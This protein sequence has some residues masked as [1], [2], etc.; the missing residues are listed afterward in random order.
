MRSSFR[1]GS[2]SFVEILANFRQK[3]Q[4][5]FLF[6]GLMLMSKSNDVYVLCKCIWDIGSK[7]EVVG[8]REC[9]ETAGL[10]AKNDCAGEDQQQ[11]I[12]PTKSDWYGRVG[13][14]FI[15]LSLFL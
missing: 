4:F 7:Y 11:F 3:M 6:S 9:G 10:G 13:H 12:R 8:E 5:L 15:L 2:A 1:V 14:I